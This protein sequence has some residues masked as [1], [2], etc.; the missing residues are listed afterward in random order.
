MLYVMFSEKGRYSYN[1]YIKGA[2]APVVEKE[3]GS[4]MTFQNGC[5]DCGLDIQ[6]DC[7]A[8]N[9]TVRVAPDDGETIY[10]LAQDSTVGWNAD[11]YYGRKKGNVQ[12]YRL[13]DTDTV[14]YEMKP[15]S[16][17]V[18]GEFVYRN[19]GGVLMKY[20]IDSVLG[21][22]TW[23]SMNH[24]FLKPDVIDYRTITATDIY[25]HTCETPGRH[26]MV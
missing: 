24:W 26:T 5:Y 3:N 9:E 8:D 6:S 21:W 23:D 22:E 4:S 14:I 15:G 16:W 20:S 25:Y 7:S 13:R 17:F 10:I 19:D 2:F 12:L 11:S 1:K 18:S